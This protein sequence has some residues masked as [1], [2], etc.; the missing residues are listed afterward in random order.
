MYLHVRKLKKSFE[1]FIVHCAE[2]DVIKVFDDKLHPTEKEMFEYLRQLNLEKYGFEKTIEV[3]T[4]TDE[5]G[6]VTK[7][8]TIH[9]KVTD[10]CSRVAFWESVLERNLPMKFRNS[11]IASTIVKEVKSRLTNRKTNSCTVMLEIHPRGLLVNTPNHLVSK[12][13]ER[14]RHWWCSAVAI[15]YN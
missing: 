14:T 10:D 12:R 13:S 4:E 11:K 15:N 5:Y 9:Y 7:K 1:Y 2:V 8:K 6:K 3:S